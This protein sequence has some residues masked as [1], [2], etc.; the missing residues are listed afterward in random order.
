MENCARPPPGGEVS[1]AQMWCVGQESGYNWLG[2]TFSMVSSMEV[3]RKS[4]ILE[5]PFITSYP[6][7]QEWKLYYLDWYSLRQLPW[8]FPLYG[9]VIS[10]N[11]FL[12][13]IGMQASVKF[14]RLSTSK[15]LHHRSLY[16]LT[17]NFMT[18]YSSELS[19]YFS[20]SSHRSRCLWSHEI[21]FTSTEKV[22]CFI[23]LFCL[24]KSEW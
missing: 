2:F 1:F 5:S 17:R 23:F 16:F 8:Y 9:V 11:R 15:F 22:S 6:S 21:F 14:R 12:G 7:L 18:A 24:W 20:F 19:I 13:L 4:F 10:L 3:Y